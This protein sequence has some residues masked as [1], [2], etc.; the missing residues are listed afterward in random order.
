MQSLWDE[1]AAAEFSGDLAQRVYSSRLLGRDTTLVLHGGG[2]TSV[3]S[4][5]PD[6]FGEAQ[7]VLYIKGSGWDLATIEAQG[8]APVALAPVARLAELP[9]LSDTRMV[10]ALKTYCL[11]PAAPSP[12]V[13]TILHAIIPDKFV[14]HTHADAVVTITNT[15]QGRA[16]IEEI[17]G[18]DV[19]IVPYIMPGFDL[20]R[21]CAR[22]LQAQ[23]HSGSIG[24]VLMNHGI[25]SFGA[26]AR[27]AYERMIDLV[28]RA[29]AYLRENQAWHLPPVQAKAVAGVPLRR[30]QLRQQV[31]QA[32]GRALLMSSHLGERV[33]AFA[34]REDIASISQQGP[35]TP[36]HVIR[37]KRLPLVGTDVAAYSEQYREYFSAHNSGD[38]TMLDPAPRV[39]L[40]A[41]LGFCTCGATAKDAAV[42]YDIYAH[43]MDVIERAQ[44]L[45]AYK[46][47]PAQDLFDMEYWELEQAKLRKPG[48]P[49]VFQGEV[50]LVTG[51]ASG[52]GR[53]CVDE[54]LQAGAAVV[55]LDISA[56]VCELYQR[57][58]YLGIV[59]DVTDEAH[60]LR[61]IEQAVVRFGGI[62]MLVLN[63]GMF[64]AGCN[65]AQLATEQWRQVM[66]LNLDANMVLL[67]EC[68][69]YLR[70][71]HRHGRVVVIGSKNVPAPGPGA[72][73]YS[74]AKAALNQL[75]RVVALEWG[76]DSIRINTVHPNMVFDTAIWTDEVL[77]SRAE[78]YGMSVAEYKTNNVLRTQISSRDVA[79][80]C[81]AMC[82]PL[83]AKTTGAQL[84]VDGGNERVI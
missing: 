78:H 61:A 34:Q 66:A 13:E 32:A 27:E 77:Q 33:N 18:S 71:A 41:D 81:A 47:L 29:E 39:I 80:L 38:N 62:D 4:Q 43:T 83:F 58:D 16:R 56:S 73:A 3:K 57:A 54:F 2:N 8:F 28:A 31:S 22:E 68:Y 69:P 36:D 67:R 53:A 5:C 25:F 12:S 75:L 76:K 9:E 37:T 45:G 14:D 23:R 48:R 64:P 49:P 17:Y 26:T 51:G 21:L 15:E 60:I 19:I 30:A 70:L 35:A 7:D 46:A 59:C 6:I 74:S 72:A 55:A 65:V 44:M 20:A 52:I 10:Q 84:P 42:V 82:G 40:D 24:M 79:A 1:V 63:A 50:V 11:D